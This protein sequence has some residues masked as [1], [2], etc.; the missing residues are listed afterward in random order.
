MLLRDLFELI[1]FQKF[2]KGS[3]ENFQI[4]SMCQNNLSGQIIMILESGNVIKF[5]HFTHHQR[6][7]T[8][9]DVIKVVERQEVE[10]DRQR[11]RKRKTER[12]KIKLQKCSGNAGE[13]V[14][15]FS[16]LGK[17]GLS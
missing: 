9:K 14:L 5:L 6:I 10:E 15:I 8:S 12:Q 13:D 11:L 3:H 16:I 1:D 2:K 17:D 7:A 4:F